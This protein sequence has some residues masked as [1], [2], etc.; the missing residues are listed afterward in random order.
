[1]PFLNV[2][3]RLTFSDLFLYFVYVLFILFACSSSL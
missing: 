2:N 3:R 1:M